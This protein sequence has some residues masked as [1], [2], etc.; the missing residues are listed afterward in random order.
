M[1]RTFKTK[2]VSRSRIAKGNI[3]DQKKRR[4]GGGSGRR[5]YGR[6]DWGGWRVGEQRERNAIEL[7]NQRRCK[8]ER[9]GREEKGRPREEGACEKGE[10]L[11]LGHMT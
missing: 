1:D 5:Q 2:T 11:L 6:G 9:T 7:G 8:G 10:V 4:A 3:N